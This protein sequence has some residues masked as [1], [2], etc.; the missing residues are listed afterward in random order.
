MKVVLT[1]GGAREHAIGWRLRQDDPNIELHAFPGNAGLAQ[2][3]NCRADVAHD[4]VDA[5]MEQIHRIQPGLVIAGPEAGLAAGLGNEV[6]KAGIPFVGPSKDGAMLEASKVHACDI[7]REAGIPQPMG[8]M[9][10]TST[11]AF[12]FADALV[13]KQ[14]VIKAEGLC[15]GKGVILPNS[16]EEAG[17]AI[18]GMLSGQLFGDAGKRILIQ[19][20]LEGREVSFMLVTDGMNLVSLPTS[21]DYK[22]R[23]ENDEGPNT[24]GMG[25]VSPNLWLTATLEEQII[26]EIVRPLLGQLRKQGVYYHGFLYVGIMLTEDGPKVLEFNVRLGDP[27]ASVILPLLGGNFLDLMLATARGELAG[28]NIKP[29]NLSGT[30]VVSVAGGYPGKYDKG[31]PIYGLDDAGAEKEVLVFHAGTAFNPRLNEIVTSGGRIL[32][33]VALDLNP[34]AA[35]VKAHAAEAM[36]RF[37]DKAKRTDIGTFGIPR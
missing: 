13:P 6:R 25:A 18:Q 26:T 11:Q 23:H 33:T 30:C 34:V 16:M 31:F 5:V 17:E 9:F 7:M 8:S 28:V 22:R 29:S 2:I 15:G 10:R 12:N 14:I 36:I 24:G 21:M 27:E 19:E 4:D 32:N 1:G 37:R 3:G 35:T 20:R